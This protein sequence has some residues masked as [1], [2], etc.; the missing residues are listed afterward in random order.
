MVEPLARSADS[1]H[2]R[3][4]ERELLMVLLCDYYSKH[5]VLRAILNKQRHQQHK[6]QNRG[7]FVTK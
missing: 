2:R 7:L 4:K 3:A 6:P 1:R 5:K